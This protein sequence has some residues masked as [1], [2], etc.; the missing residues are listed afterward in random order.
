MANNLSKVPTYILVL[1]IVLVQLLLACALAPMCTLQICR[2]A[3]ALK[4]GGI[5]PWRLSVRPFVTSRSDVD[6]A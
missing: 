2:H 5:H 4:A 3:F 1:E 6:T